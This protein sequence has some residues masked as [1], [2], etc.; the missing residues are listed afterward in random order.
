ME[1]FDFLP[2]KWIARV[3]Y[4]GVQE[5]ISEKFDIH[6]AALDMGQAYIKRRMK[7]DPNLLWELFELTVE[8][9]SA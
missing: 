6:D 4:S 5:Y 9:V 2:C 3:Q 8:S 7:E 1:D